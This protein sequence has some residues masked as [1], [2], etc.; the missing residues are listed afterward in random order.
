MA[1]KICRDYDNDE[2]MAELGRVCVDLFL[3]TQWNGDQEKYR[4]RISGA[5]YTNVSGVCE[6]EQDEEEADAEDD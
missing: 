4:E 1:T 6:D 5:L 2:A 3:H